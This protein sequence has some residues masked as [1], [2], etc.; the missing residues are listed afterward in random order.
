MKSLMSGCSSDMP[1]RTR[2]MPPQDEL[3]R[4]LRY[5]K[6]T[7][8]L[9]WMERP[10]SNRFNGARAGK[11]ASHEGRLGYMIVTIYNKHWMAHR[12]IW[13]L[14]YGQEPAEVDHIS[15][16]RNDNRLSNLRASDRQTNMR[17]L[18]TRKDNSSGHIGVNRTVDGTWRAYINEDGRFRNLGH[19][20]TFDEVCR[21]RV[22][23]QNRLNFHQN[24]GRKAATEMLHG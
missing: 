24:H 1:I 12:I 4:L 21:A 9:Y 23:A 11:I 20:K 19:F 8:N 16:R 10:G 18:R 7:G 22:A 5:D 17:N 14:I 13:K 15:G 2:T 3:A 6:E